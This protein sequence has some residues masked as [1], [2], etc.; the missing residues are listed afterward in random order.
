MYEDYRVGVESLLV[1][2][3]REQLMPSASMPL[4]TLELCLREIQA[5][6]AGQL[7]HKHE[8]ISSRAIHKRLRSIATR[9][10]GPAGR[11]PST[12]RFACFLLVVELFFEW[13][14]VLWGNLADFRA[15][16]FPSHHRLAPEQARR[17]RRCVGVRSKRPHRVLGQSG[18]APTHASLA[19]I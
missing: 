5:G 15:R 11:A 8:P 1:F 13:G 18:Q 12:C 7:L 9:R 2:T 10:R 17:T 14:C 16:K 4:S 19:L 6:V 3:T